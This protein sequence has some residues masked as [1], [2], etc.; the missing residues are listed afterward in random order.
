[1]VGDKTPKLSKKLT[2]II[3]GNPMCFSTMHTFQI[4]EHFVRVFE[5][6]TS[7]VWGIH[8]F[9]VVNASH[10][11]SVNTVLRDGE[12]LEK[13]NNDWIKL[14]EWLKIRMRWEYNQVKRNIEEQI[15]K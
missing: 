12:V 13:G 8:L 1:M 9:N 4:D 2:K 7:K 10:K 15:K 14:K 11:A 3:V 6:C 5:R